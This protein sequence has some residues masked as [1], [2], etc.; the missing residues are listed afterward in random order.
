MIAPQHLQHALS[1]LLGDARLAVTALPGTELKL[2]L[3]D[4]ANMDRAFSP[5]ETRR[6]L[7][8]PPYWSFCWAS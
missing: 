1:E 6:I 8:D 7:E 5:D 2:W 4:E 3:I